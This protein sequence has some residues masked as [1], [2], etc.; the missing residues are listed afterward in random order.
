MRSSVDEV[1]T[2][3]ERTRLWLP[4]SS[5]LRTTAP[6]A[7]TIVSRASPPGVCSTC[8]SGLSTRIRFE[9]IAISS[10]WRI[11]WAP[12]MRAPLTQVPLF[13]PRSSTSH[14]PALARSRACCRDTR[15]SGTK[16]W[17]SERR[18]ITYSPS[19]SA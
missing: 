3:V 14:L 6:W 5:R 1:S 16:I 17:Q 13:E 10:P 8:S 2:P 7:S 4:D 15:M 12:A 19:L 18:P 11:G 9:E